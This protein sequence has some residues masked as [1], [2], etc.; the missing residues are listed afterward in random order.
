MC[1]LRLDLKSLPK[2]LES[3]VE[4]LAWMETEELLERRE[5]AVLVTE[6]GRPFVRNVAMAFDRYLE[7]RKSQPG[8]SRA[9]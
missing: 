7:E 9:I 8:F 5:G 4:S 2:N 1:E 6:K 3:A